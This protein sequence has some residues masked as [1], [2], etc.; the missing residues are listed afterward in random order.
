[1]IYEGS[2]YEQAQTATVLN[3]EGFPAKAIFPQE[4]FSTVFEYREYVAEFG[5]RFD[6]LAARFYGDAE[7]WWLI[8]RAN[9]EIFF[10][11]DPLPA[12]LT[13]RIP[14]DIISSW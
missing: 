3:K 13:L 2:R 9:P 10:P 5:D 6:V 7:R 8:A 12:G 1:M 11:D 4:H 14:D